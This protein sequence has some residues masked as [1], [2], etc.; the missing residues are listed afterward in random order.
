MTEEEL[1]AAERGSYGV[2]WPTMVELVAEIRRLRS[3][4]AEMTKD[5]D[6]WIDRFASE[7]N[8]IGDT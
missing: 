1:N 8:G 4:L 2:R 3:E 7:S 6:L 5:R